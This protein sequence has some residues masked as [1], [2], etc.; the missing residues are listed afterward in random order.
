MH[1]VKKIT[2]INIINISGMHCIEMQHLLPTLH[3]TDLC[4]DGMPVITIET[5]LPHEIQVKCQPVH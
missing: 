4:L 5:D 3:R 1:N 2:K